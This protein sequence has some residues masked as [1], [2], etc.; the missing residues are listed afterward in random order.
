[1][2]K[3]SQKAIAKK[4]S[5]YGILSEIARRYYIEGETQDTIASVLNLSRMK[6]NRMLREA[7]EAGLVE[8]RVQFHSSQ[9]RKI[10]HEICKTFGLKHLLVAPQSHSA[11]R[12]RLNVAM[13]V[14]HYLESNLREGQVVT[15]GMGRNVAATAMIQA[16]R[17]F[18]NITFVSGSGGASEAGTES[19]ADH[20]CR[21]LAARFGGK[22]AS[23][24]APAFVAD[25]YLR[26]SLMQNETV[27][28]TLNLAKSADYALIG[29]GDLG[30]DSH[31]ARMGWF[32]PQEMAQARKSGVVGD[33][34]GYD[35]FDIDGDPCNAELGGRVIGLSRED[36]SRI[37]TT[38]AIASEASKTTAIIGALRTG[39]I[40]VLATSLPNCLAICETLRA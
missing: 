26:E 14:N 3:I 19:N 29:I 16:G 39:A 31:M 34:M 7:Q 24:Y 30:T 6:V 13:L 12:Q 8:I 22:A 33:I 5:N 27:R 36:L 15:V 9:T 1:M 10:E 18:E 40:D 37:G 11:E 23:L 35:F 2:S 25:P 17:T 20:I 28:R 4:S 21:N 32:S 38:I